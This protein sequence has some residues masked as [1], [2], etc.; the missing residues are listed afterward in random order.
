MADL[1]NLSNRLKDCKTK[2]ERL[3][4]LANLTEDDKQA[5]IKVW[6]EVRN[7]WNIFGEAIYSIVYKTPHCMRN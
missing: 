2:E 6:E 7:T 5:L 3:E 1:T 4:F